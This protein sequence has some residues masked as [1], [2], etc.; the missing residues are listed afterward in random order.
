MTM[1]RTIASQ[2]FSLVEVLVAC[3][4]LTTCLLPVVVLSQRGLTES[5]TTQEEILGRQILMDMCD[6]FKACS[7]ADLEKVAQNPQ[8]IKDDPLLQPLRNARADMAARGTAQM[9]GLKIDRKLYFDKEW[10]GVLG[11]H[12]LRFEV[13]WDSRRGVRQTIYLSRLIHCH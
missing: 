3:A 1:C 13:S 8:L 12:R 7:P 5:A 11:M 4:I 6:R 2:G 9:A 10:K